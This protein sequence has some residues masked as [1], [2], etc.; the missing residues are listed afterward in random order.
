MNINKLFKYTLLGLCAAPLAASAQVELADKQAQKVTLG[1]EEEISEFL[2]TAAT[3]TITAEELQRTSAVSLADALYGKLLGLTATQ[4]TG[5]KG[6]EGKGASFNIRGI[7]TKAGSTEDYQ[8]AND[9]LI[10]VD[11]VE[12]PIDRISVE[13][14]ES[15]TVLK[16]AAAVALFGHEGINGVLYVKTKRGQANSGNHIKAGYSHKF[17]F[18]PQFAD[19]V[20][21]YGYANAL[22]R[23]RQND[24]L[25]LAYTDAELAKFQDGSDPYVYPN[26]NWRNEAF[27]NTADENQAYVS[28]YGGSD[29]VQYYTQLNYTDARGLYKNTVQDNWDSQLKYSKANIRANV[30]FKISESTKVSASMLAIFMEINGLNGVNSNDAWWHLYKTPAVAFPVQ[31]QNGVWGGSQTFGDFNILA[32]MQGTGFQKT[33]QRQIWADMVLNQDLSSLVKGLKFYIGASYDNSSNIIEQNVKGYQYGWNYYDATGSLAETVMGTV[34]DKLRFSNWVDTQWR[35]ATMNVGLKYNTM[36]DNGD[37]LGLNANYN[38]K[39]EFR[40]GQHH[41]W[42]RANGQLATHYD[43]ANKFVADLVLAANGSNRCYP[44]KWAFS[45]TLGLGYIFVN[46]D[47]DDAFFNYGKVRG[48]AGIQHTDFTPEAGLWLSPW[49]ASHGSFVHSNNFAV[50]WGAFLQAFPTEN[51]L[52]ETAYKANIGTDFRLMKSLDLTVDGFYQKRTNILVPA[53]QLNSAVVGI[54]S[55]YDDKGMVSSYGVEAGLRYAKTFANDFSLYGGAML[56]AYKSQ[57]DAWIENPAYDNLS[58]IG[59]PADAARGLVA[60]GFFESEEDIAGSPRQEF[61]QVK[62][63][64]IKYKDV[65]GD[66]VINENDY[67]ALDYGTSFPSLNYAFNLGFEFKG[68]GIN[69]S[70]QGAGNQIKNIHYVDGVWG[71]LS[72]N[73]NLSVEYNNNCWDAVGA[74][75]LYPRL[76]TEQVANNEQASTIWYRN[77]QW[78]KMRDCELY[79]RLP[80]SV[81]SSYRISGAKVFLQGQNLLS[82]SNIGALDAENL[83]TGYPVMKSVNLGLSV[84]F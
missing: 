44:A 54:Q 65:N 3:T 60:L 42:Y 27:K 20:D 45:P 71:A 10:L 19:M 67:V 1:Y 77:V 62:P 35:I 81:T 21:A 72:D 75:A 64:D 2:T 57:V 83:N 13:E 22:N 74:S 30:D 61:G 70:F 73:R 25:A 32:K 4:N 33:H 6:E 53:N 52:Q 5:F 14:V 41:T 69:A 40:D 84:T 58:I 82:W 24:G 47:D 39:G 43:H 68:V 50:S 12:R 37:H 9:I 8:D 7:Q 11:G 76:S 36:F 48:S 79:Y 17:Q 66:N 34:E 18:D 49:D 29:K 31:T 38:I 78:F 26:V 80:E 56:T 63:G 59:D 28:M 46:N 23:A 15:V 16:D 55:A 51:F